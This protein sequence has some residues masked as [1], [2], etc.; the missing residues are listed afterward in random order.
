MSKLFNFIL[1]LLFQGIIKSD[2]VDENK[3]SFQLYPSWEQDLPFYFYAQANNELMTINSTDGD[4][5]NILERK[6]IE[7]YSYKDLSSAV[8]IDDTYLVK[9]CFGPDKLVEIIDKNKETFSHNN[10]NLNETKF[11]YSTKVYNPLINDEHSDDYVI[12]TYWTEIKSITD[13]ERYSHKCIFFYPKTKTFSQELT[14]TSGSQFVI[15]IYYPEKCVTFRDSDIFCVIHYVPAE[16]DDVHILGNNYVIETKNIILDAIYS[17]KQSVNLVISNSQ[18]SSNIYQRPIAL[19][20]TSNSK[21][22]FIDI[23]MTE[24]HNSEGEGKVSLMYSYYRKYIHTSYIPFTSNV[25]IGINIEDNY[26]HQDLFNYLVPNKDELIIIYISQEDKMSLILNRFNASD[27][28]SK[29]L[30]KG[31]KNYAYNSYIR[32]DIC[33]KPK[34]LQSIYINSFIS[35]DDKDKNIINSNPNTNYYKYQKDIGVLISC[36]NNENGIEYESKRIKLPQ[37][38]NTLDELNGNDKHI[39]KFNENENEIIFDIYN[40]PNLAS[41]RNSS[42]IFYKPEIFSIYINTFIKIEGLPDFA[43]IAYNATISGITHIKFKKSQYYNELKSGKTFS[44]PYRL[45]KNIITNGISSNIISDVCNIDTSPGEKCP[46]EHCSICKDSTHCSRCETLI[47][48]MTLDNNKNSETYGKCM[49]DETKNF[50][51]IPLIIENNEVCACKKNYFYFSDK[52]YCISNDTAKNGPFYNIGKDEL[53]GIDIFD[54][55]YK[56]CQKCSNISNSAAAQYCTECKIGYKLQGIN[57]VPEGPEPTTPTPPDQPKNC[58]EEKKVWFELGKFKFEYLKIDKCVFIFFEDQLFFISNKTKCRGIDTKRYSYSYLSQ[59]IINNNDIGEEM[60]YLDFLSFIP[61]Y[62]ETDDKIS[63]TKRVQ[64]GDKNILFHLVNLKTNAKAKNISHLYFENNAIYDLIVFKADIKKNGTFSTQVEYQF[65][66]SDNEHIHERVDKSDL[67]NYKIP[68]NNNGRLLD[69]NDNI[70]LELPVDWKDGELEKIKEL[71]SKGINAF[72]TTSAFY[73]DVCFKY[74]TPDNEDIYLQD[75]KEKYYPGEEFCE[76]Q[77]EFLQKINFETG[78]VICRCPIKEDTSKYNNITFKEPERNEEFNKKYINPHYKVIG[79]SGVSKTLGKNFGFYWAFLSLLIFLCLCA[80]RIKDI[81][82]NNDNVKKKLKEFEGEIFQNKEKEEKEEEEEEKDDEGGDKNIPFKDEKKKDKKNLKL[83]SSS[84]NNEDISDRQ[85]NNEINN[86]KDNENDNEKEKDKENDKDK[87]TINSNGSSL[88]ASGI[89]KESDIKNQEGIKTL[90]QFDSSK[91]ENNSTVEEN[92]NKK[93]EKLTLQDNKNDIK[94]SK[95]D[96][97][98]NKEED[99]DIKSNNENN[100]QNNNKDNISQSQNESENNYDRDKDKDKEEN[101]TQNLNINDEIEKDKDKEKEKEKEV[102]SDLIDESKDESNNSKNLIEN[103]ENTIHIHIEEDERKEDNDDKRE[104]NNEEREYNDDERE[105]NDDDKREDNNDER[106]D[107]DDRNED[108]DDDK[109]EDNDDKK[110]DNDEKKEPKAEKLKES[111]QKSQ[112]KNSV[113]RYLNILHG[114]TTIKNKD[115]EGNENNNMENKEN[116][117][118]TKTKFNKL[119]ESYENNKVIDIDEYDK[120]DTSMIKNDQIKPK[121]SITETVNINDLIQ[122]TTQNNIDKSTI[123]INKEDNNTKNKEEKDISTIEKANDDDNENNNDDNE[124]NKD[125]INE[126]NLDCINLGNEDLN[127]GINNNENLIASQSQDSESKNSVMV[128][129]MIP[130]FILKKKKKKPKTVAN[131]PPKDY[132]NK[133]GDIIIEEEAN[134]EIKYKNNKSPESKRELIDSVYDQKANIDKNNNNYESDRISI[135]EEN[136]VDNA[137]DKK[138]KFFNK[139]NFLLNRKSYDYLIANIK[140]KKLGDN[141]SF[142]EML[143]SVVE[144]NSTIMYLCYFQ[145]D[146]FFI[147]FSILVL[148]ANLYLFVT[149]SLQYNM[150]MLLLYNNFWFGGFL[151]Y[152]F[153]ACLVSFPII[154]CKKYLSVYDLFYEMFSTHIDY[155]YSENIK[156]SKHSIKNSKTSVKISLSSSTIQE[157]NESKIRNKISHYVDNVLKETIIYTVIGV[158]FLV[159]NIVFITSFCGIY[160]NSIKSLFLNTFVSIL[161]SCFLILVFRSIGVALRYFGLKKQNELMYNIS[162]FFNILNLTWN[163]FYEIICQK[164]EEKK[165]NE[166]E[167]K[168]EKKDKKDIKK[169]IKERPDDEI[170]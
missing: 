85:N 91:S 165:D 73:L 143:L 110:E 100:E 28:S 18:I 105:Y 16:S 112:I 82:S 38:L 157:R 2:D 46:V 47:L 168:E 147:K 148:C 7:E 60:K 86:E 57:C 123:T 99:N 120:D 51:K 10:N 128:N 37:C 17:Q 65:Y 75:R 39:L 102:K 151:L 1:F 92:K 55:C 129:Q 163:D 141:R 71:D 79:C 136:S 121:E 42:I 131:P 22:G 156:T 94:S 155:I 161:M 98:N 162:R 134:K 6:E 59:C 56:T 74:T 26:V 144:S 89:I 29:Q 138:S 34:Y 158:I 153:I 21:Y 170:V 36:D 122:N 41:L 80:K 11:C 8:I 109:R 116:T 69:E 53:T 70:I 124:D 72:D 125:D 49:C 119:L 81:Y 111:I 48:G 64:E 14:L 35:Y 152:A 32:T 12:L 4:N 142:F 25:F 5:C 146:D 84:D 107:N 43:N 95:E 137:E 30:N 106:E 117:E 27:S 133:S 87:E 67:H 24:Y 108:N 83:S 33:D 66:K 114:S 169:N 15:N 13:R 104:D 145:I 31:F 63:I 97:S 154:I 127:S 44:L 150:T 164:K 23:Y 52:S 93:N 118:I 166:K 62:N 58:S 90:T 96:E 140:N 139:Y 45:K 101:I 61:E 50:E 54:N 77:C 167:E 115:N 9:T 159:I 3:Y 135:N 88:K 78:N 103:S 76:E 40:D 20:K 113:N 130:S 19:K 68:N 160:P 132:D 126:D 149:A